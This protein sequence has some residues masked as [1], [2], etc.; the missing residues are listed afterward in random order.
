MD[1]FWN[2]KPLAG[3][4]ESQVGI[5]GVNMVEPKAPEAPK[6]QQVPKGMDAVRFK[7]DPNAVLDLNSDNFRNIYRKQSRGEKLG[8]AEQNFLSDLKYKTQFEGKSMQEVLGV[9][10]KVDKEAKY[11]NL[12]ME[13]RNLSSGDLR[14]NLASSGLNYD[15]IEKVIWYHQPY[16]EYLQTKN[17]L[18]SRS[19]E[20]FARKKELIDKQ[21]A[22]TNHQIQENWKNRMNTLNTGLSFTGFGRSSEAISRRD[23]VTRS[24][25]AEMSI[26]Q[27]KAQ[28]ELQ[29]YQAQL[30]G[31]DAETLGALSQNLA[32]YTNA[33]KNQQTENALLAQKLNDEANVSMKA[34]LDNMI[35]LSWVNENEIDKELSKELGFLVN[36]K[37]AAVNLGEDG[38][39]IYLLSGR[40]QNYDEFKD[41]RDYNY[42][43]YK[44]DKDF[45]LKERKFAHDVSVDNSKLSIDSARLDLDRDK[46]N[47]EMV[48]DDIKQEKQDRQDLQNALYA[49]EDAKTMIDEFESLKDNWM[50][51]RQMPS[52]A[53]KIER[54]RTSLAFME[55]QNL[56]AKGVS[57]NPMTDNDFNKIKDSASSLSA[58]MTQYEFNKE[59]DRI[60]WVIQKWVDRRFWK[61]NYKYDFD[62]G[63]ILPLDKAKGSVSSKKNFS[64][65]E[66]SDFLDW[67]TEKLS[68]NK[69][70]KDFLN[71]PKADQTALNKGLMN[72][73]LASTRTSWQCGAFVNDYVENLTW[74][75]IMWD[76]YESK[77]KHINSDKPL[78]GSLAVWNPGGKYAKNG[79]TWIVLS[80]DWATVTIKD[81]NWKWDGKVMVR[82]V[83]ISSI[84]NKDWWFVNFS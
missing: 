3:Y 77:K 27:A 79:H 81:A 61:Y 50:G 1:R 29:L 60:Q 74:K 78:S 52:V 35:A 2:F 34:A 39:P 24:V 49:A 37:G 25:N 4:D 43:V 56:K 46:F 7:D 33:L 70:K 72:K 8:L 63:E 9:E 10:T 19:E 58:A 64:D 30:Q 32:S 84:L 73:A 65:K 57:M 45:G 20:A 82:K 28:A 68:Y 12:A 14:N 42:N 15:E 55:V 21:L 69:T 18:K 16:N 71:F 23:D 36:K 80:V 41:N 66:A 38:K 83:P 51:S 47:F 53:A 11:K 48:K 40:K 75:R 26:A 31:A 59:I 62:T 6:I 13:N 22:E 17:E 5:P 67:N 76:S 44:D 54:L